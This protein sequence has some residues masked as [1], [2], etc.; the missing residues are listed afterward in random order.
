M[1]EE[2]GLSKEDSAKFEIRKR[3]MVIFI[4]YLAGKGRTEDFLDILCDTMESTGESFSYDGAARAAVE[5]MFTSEEKE[6]FWTAVE[7]EFASMSLAQS[8]SAQKPTGKADA[9]PESWAELPKPQKDY[10]ARASEKFIVEGKTL[11]I[12]VDIFLNELLAPDDTLNVFLKDNPDMMT[13]RKKKTTVYIWFRSACQTH[14]K[15]IDDLFKQAIYETIKKRDPLLKNFRLDPTD[16]D[17]LVNGKL[18][19]S[20]VPGMEEIEERFY[21]GV[22]NAIKEATLEAFNTYKEKYDEETIRKAKE[23][24][25]KGKLSEMSREDLLARHLVD[26]ILQLKIHNIN[27]VKKAAMGMLGKDDYRQIVGAGG[28]IILSEGAF[29]DLN[30]ISGGKFGKSSLFVEADLLQMYNATEKG[31]KGDDIK[32]TF[33]M[34]VDNLKPD[35]LREAIIAKVITRSFAWCKLYIIKA[36]QDALEG[37]FGQHFFEALKVMKD[38]MLKAETEEGSV[39]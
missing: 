35:D 14:R 8:K 32:Q 33:G 10:L 17:D 36:G 11:D 19:N 29:G 15:R 30:R 24:A 7:S 18:K 34:F 31:P 16:R 3:L 27:E 13:G 20:V 37:L 26:I 38:D 2:L 25:E 6:E 22:C 4:H 28:V 5:R 1:A 23:K 39:A 21:A 12:I 9:P